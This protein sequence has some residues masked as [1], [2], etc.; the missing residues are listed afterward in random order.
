MVVKL[1]LRGTASTT[2]IWAP[3]ELVLLNLNSRLPSWVYVVL[4]TG[5]PIRMRDSPMTVTFLL[6]SRIAPDGV[7]TV[8]FDALMLDGST[9]SLSGIYSTASRGGSL[10]DGKP[11]M[12]CTDSAMVA[13]LLS[14][15]YWYPI[16]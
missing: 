13:V 10:I 11:A 9:G 12:P 6:S 8:T 16:P 1:P 7:E 15:T 4:D 5:M 14:L 2:S 3:V